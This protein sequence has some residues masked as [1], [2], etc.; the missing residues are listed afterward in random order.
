MSVGRKNLVGEW[1]FDS[2]L[3]GGKTPDTSG[4]GNHGE[5]F[6]TPVITIGYNGKGA[7]TLGDATQYIDIGSG[8]YLSIFT[9]SA[10]IHGNSDVSSYRTII[11]KSISPNNRNYWF[12]LDQ[13]TGFLVLRFSVGSIAHTFATTAALN[14]NKWHHVAATYDNSFV[15]IYIDGILSHTDP[16][17]GLPDNPI[18]NA[19]I[20]Y[21]SGDAGLRSLK[22]IID[23]VRIY[24]VSLSPTEILELSRKRNPLPSFQVDL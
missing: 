2:P 22:G 3:I 4:Y 9:L 18:I 1:K 21:E 13:G 23:D 14:D 15:N 5:L 8:Q 20:G 6:G 11:S 12:Q 17:S 10:W 19:R 24:S 16:Q 7:Y